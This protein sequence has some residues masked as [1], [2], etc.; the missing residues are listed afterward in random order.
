MQSRAKSWVLNRWVLNDKQYAK[1]EPHMGHCSY[2][3]RDEYL[4]YLVHTISDFKPE[5]HD[6]PFVHLCY[7]HIL[8]IDFH[9][10]MHRG[11]VIEI[12]TWA[13]TDGRNGMR[14]DWIIKDSAI[15]EIIGRATR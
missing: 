14:R 8:M 9:H 11:R 1:I 12:E 10:I 3:H 15:S 4:S 13:Q 6:I 5:P 2:A 7:M